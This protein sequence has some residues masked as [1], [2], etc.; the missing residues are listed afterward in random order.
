[1][2][3]PLL[4]LLPLAALGF[5]PAP[6][7][8]ER[9]DD[10]EVILRRLQGDWRGVAFKQDGRDLY[11]GILFRVSLEKDR[12][13]FSTGNGA[14][15]HYTIALDTKAKP[16]RIDWRE[17]STHLVGLF[18]VSGDGF[19]YSFRDAAKGYPQSLTNPEAGDYVVELV[20]AK[21]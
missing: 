10:R 19:R 17:G 8:R 11:A 13:K 9:P 3:K 16:M 1:M 5:A 21:K 14:G 20:R 6:V 2:R 4:L 18:E 7:Y 12:W 15:S